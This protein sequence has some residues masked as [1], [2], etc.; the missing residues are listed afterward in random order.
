MNYIGVFRKNYSHQSQECTKVTPVT[1]S[2]PFK[3]VLRAASVAFLTA[4]LLTTGV[5]AIGAGTHLCDGYASCARQGMGNGGYAAVNNRMYWRMYSGHNCT[6]YAAYRMVASGMPNVRPWEGGGNAVYWGRYM[7]KYTDDVPRVGAIA[8]WNDGSPG[9][10]AYVEKVVSPNEIIISQD[11]WGGDFSWARVT[12]DYRWPAGFI[13]FNDR[14]LQSISAP[15]ASGLPKVGGRVTATAGSWNPSP[16]SV[17]YR[18]FVAGDLLPRATERTVT[19]AP[20]MQGKRLRVAVVAHRAG[21][22]D[23]VATTVVTDSILPGTLQTTEE[24]RLTGTNTVGRTLRA[25]TGSWAPGPVTTSYRWLVDGE[26]VAG[27]TQPRLWLGPRSAGRRVAFTV[28]ATRTGYEPV[29]RTVTTAPVHRADLHQVE[30]STVTGTPLRGETMRVHPGAVREEATRS[31]QWLRDGDPIPGA[32]K[33]TYQLVKA[34]VTHQIRAAVTF[35]RLGYHS[36]SE[37]P[38]GRTV[39]G[40]VRLATTKH[41][42]RGGIVFDVVATVA[43]RPIPGP[44]AISV[45]GAG[46]IRDRAVLRDGHAR[47]VVKQMPRGERRLWFY[48]DR[49][50]I[51]VPKAALRKARFR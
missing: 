2:H 51:S 47:L 43:G 38:G 35:S 36:V 31:I 7:A 16:T 46:S 28:T 30:R 4:G 42:V 5:P 40:T 17:E 45:R 12:R 27:A 25:T 13:H 14:E 39:K 50:D 18:W 10:V 15:R 41:R 34:D 11:S 9:H 8:W 33:L 20:W 26:P 3:P 37:T 6:N 24:P 49:T 1:A 19:L 22:P 23:Q 32:T 44:T 29:T 21:Y 48:V